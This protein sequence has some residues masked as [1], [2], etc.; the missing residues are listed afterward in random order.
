[1]SRHAPHLILLHWLTALAVVLA[2]ASSGDP[3]KASHALSG[4]IHVASGLAVFLL[5][6]LRLPLRLIAGVPGAEPGP[7]W[8]Q[9][10]ART[11]PRRG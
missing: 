3:S 2:Y 11:L 10:A 5:V 1:M 8:R 7:L 4:Q 6:A 9:Q